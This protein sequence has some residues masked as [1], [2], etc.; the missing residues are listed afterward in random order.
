MTPGARHDSRMRRNSWIYDAANLDEII[1]AP[2]FQLT[3][4]KSIKPYILGDPAYTLSNWLMK[5]YTH[6]TKVKVE[7]DFNYQLSRA[8]VTIERA[9]GLLKGHW[10]ILQSALNFPPEKASE[11]FVVCCILHNILQNHG[12]EFNINEN[13]E[14]DQVNVEG[15]QVSDSSSELLRTSL[16]E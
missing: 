15:L 16:A 11:I 9:F 2:L 10:R 5:P 12:E 14:S 7:K 13:F 4:L 8:R 1:Q 6:L 3:P